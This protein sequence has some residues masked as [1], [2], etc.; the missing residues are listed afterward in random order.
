MFRLYSAHGPWSVRLFDG[1]GNVLATH[2]LQA[3]GDGLHQ[4]A[5]PGLGH[6]T[7]YKFV[8]ANRELPDPYARF[9]PDGVHGPAMV[10]LPHHTWRHGDGV[11]RPLREQVIYELHVGTFTEE[12]T[13]RAAQAHLAELAD[14]GITTVELMPLNAFA[15]SRGWGYD[16]VAPFAPF[17]PYGPPD[18]LRA[19]IDEAHHLGLVVLLDVVYNHFG[20][21]GN[22]LASYSPDY[23][24][25]ELK[26]NWGDAPDFARAPMRRLVIDNARYWLREFRFDGLRLDA[27]HAM[28]D[29]S[30]RHILAE[31]AERVGE[32]QPRKL[33]MAEDDRNDGA[34]VSQVGLD[35]VWADD[36]HHAVRVSLTGERDGYFAS[37]QGGMADL[38]EAVRSG[39][40]FT[41]QPCAPGGK[42]RGKPAPELPAQAFVYCI[43]NHDQVGNRP[44]GD[45]LAHA[46]SEDAFC[47]ASTLLLYLPMTPLLFMGQEWAASTPFQFFTDHDEALGPLISEGRRQEFKHFTGFSSPDRRDAIPDPQALETFTRSRLRWSERDEPRH[48]RVL[49]VHRTLLALRRQDPVLREAGRGD[50]HL[51]GRD[52]LLVVRCTTARGQRL[53]ALNLSRAPV[54]A[55][56]LPFD[57]QTWRVLFRSDQRQAAPAAPTALAELPAETAIIFSAG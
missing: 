49:A 27:T 11:W 41:G 44:L 29:P 39:W 36:F 35:A 37:F 15:G 33:L 18:E 30:P 57:P 20:P 48:A 45:R 28:V 34:L 56:D 40:L 4:T 32:L 2:A 12:G 3:A 51:E 1:A 21:A 6:G 10:V 55:A 31:L 17:A 53:L 26:N 22:Y 38:A 24:T 42:P 52:P 43:Q 14:L 50:L 46:I 23:F 19:F 25:R 8:L 5:L 16:G 54:A 9:L 7:R 47:A 13:Y